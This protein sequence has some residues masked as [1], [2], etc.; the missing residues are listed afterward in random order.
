MAAYFTAPYWCNFTNIIGDAV[1]VT[2]LSLNRDSVEMLMG[3][4]I[5]LH[6]TVSPTSAVPNNVSWISSDNRVATVVDGVITAVKGGE[7]DIIATCQDKRYVCHVIVTEI[8]PTEVTL[9]QDE[10]KIEIGSQLNLIATVL[11]ENT[12]NKTITWE[13]TNSAVATVNDG[14]VTGVGQGECNIVAT[15]GDK[16]AVCH[17][18]VVEH[19]I[20]ITLDEHEAR[21][22]PNHLMILTPTVTPVATDLVVTSSNPAVAAARMAG[23]KI[24]VMGI[25]EGTTTIYVNSADGYAFSDSCVVEVYT[26]LGDVNCDGFVNIS[27]V[28]HLIDYLLSGDV[29]NFKPF[30]A[31]V[32]GDGNV[33]IKDVT[34][35][36]D[37]LLSGDSRFKKSKCIGNPMPIQS[38]RLIRG[39]PMPSS[40]IEPFR[41]EKDAK[42]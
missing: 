10:A 13:S 41:G 17:V 31:D 33:T 38:I 23:N 14:I 4:Q 2:D 34:G 15:C 8:L 20:Y 29:P 24:Q 27:D 36:I 25:T 3:E 11:P 5:T 40:P 18:I 1:A 19:L 28:T 32:S 37:M 9:N 21:L 26:E 7:C 30:N 22:L 39:L 16:Q 6:A 35:L 42:S 12:S